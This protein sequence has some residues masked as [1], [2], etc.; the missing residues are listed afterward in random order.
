M[1]SLDSITELA[2]SL[3]TMGQIIADYYE[4]ASNEDAYRAWYRERYGHDVPEGV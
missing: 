1:R 2:M 3:A 4:D